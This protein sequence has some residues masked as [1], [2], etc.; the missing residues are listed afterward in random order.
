MHSRFPFFSET[1]SMHFSFLPVDGQAKS[2][3][4]RS[5]RCGK[6]AVMNCRHW[7]LDTGRISGKIAPDDRVRPYQNRPKIYYVS[8]VSQASSRVRIL[9]NTE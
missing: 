7:T 3:S 4:L 2:L 8:A 6:L 1:H 9:R 5:R